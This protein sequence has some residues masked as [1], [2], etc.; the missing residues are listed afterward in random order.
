VGLTGHHPGV[1]HFI[2]GT[3]LQ[4]GVTFS[5]ADHRYEYKNAPHFLHD[6]KLHRSTKEAMNPAIMNSWF[7]QMK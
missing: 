5:M 2:K 1:L 3:L 6:C 7:N 4:A